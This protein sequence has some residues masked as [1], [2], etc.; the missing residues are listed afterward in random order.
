MAMA[1]RLFKQ[2]LLYYT[3]MIKVEKKIKRTCAHFF[4][5]LTLCVGYSTLF[6][7]HVLHA[8][9]EQ[10]AA[11]AAAAV[12]APVALTASG[13]PVQAI[14]LPVKCQR[15][16]PTAKLLLQA[17][18]NDNE[19]ACSQPSLTGD[20]VHYLTAHLD[21]LHELCFELSKNFITP[22]ITMK[23]QSLHTYNEARS[24]SSFWAILDKTATSDLEK[25]K[26]LSPARNIFQAEENEKKF[27]EVRMHLLEA[28]YDLQRLLTTYQTEHPERF[29]ENELEEKKLEKDVQK[30]ATIPA[31]TEAA[32]AY[33]GTGM[34]TPLAVAQPPSADELDAITGTDVPKEQSAANVNVGI[35]PP[36]KAKSPLEHADTVLTNVIIRAA[37]SA[38][39][40]YSPE[41]KAILRGDAAR[42]GHDLAMR[43]HEDPV[44]R[45]NPL[46]TSPIRLAFDWFFNLL[47]I[48][49]NNIFNL[50]PIGARISYQM[51]LFARRV[52]GATNQAYQATRNGIGHLKPPAQYVANSIK[53]H[54]PNRFATA[55]SVSATWLRTKLSLA[56][57]QIKQVGCR[58]IQ[59]ERLSRAMNKTRTLVENARRNDRVVSLVAGVN[60]RLGSIP[61]SRF[62]MNWGIRN[63]LQQ[64]NQYLT[65]C[66]Q[67][68]RDYFNPPP[69]Q[70]GLEVHEIM[71]QLGDS[72]AEND[73]QNK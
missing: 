67:A 11:A 59:S 10:A 37:E 42:L 56:G 23:N 62:F 64:A 30:G 54:T 15:N 26:G 65:T 32:T 49:H 31:L 27:L 21:S 14:V 24:L 25:L 36:Q 18:L 20:N 5:V 34:I 45:Y 16:M 28:Q 13:R 50:V 2:L 35:K 38:H 12:P 22:Y 72:S 52:A 48:E 39:K 4:K 57:Q 44:I 66:A 61:G 29:S 33:C 46:L 58:I 8:S 17:W 41:G 55:L 7:L 3:I 71:R 40:S 9:E 1:F 73:Q 70:R 47:R 63:Y 19:N 68:T 69:D 51:L 53:N 60:N 43:R 6:C